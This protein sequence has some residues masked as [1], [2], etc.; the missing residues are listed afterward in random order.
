MH[1]LNFEMGQETLEAFKQSQVGQ[2]KP[3]AHLEA[4]MSVMA[5]TRGA[6][7][8]CGLRPERGEDRGD[9]FGPRGVFIYLN[10]PWRRLESSRL[11]VSTPPK[12]LNNTL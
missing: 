12:V 2:S 7:A 8:P 3:A 11:A 6:W 1:T 10:E 9:I 5:A 4:D